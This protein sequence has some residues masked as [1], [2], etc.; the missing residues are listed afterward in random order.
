M[1][2]VLY[3]STWLLTA[4][5]CPFP[6]TFSGRVIDVML[7]ERRTHI[8][9]RTALAVMAET[10]A[11]L[12]ELDDFEAL[13]GHLKVCRWLAY[14]TVLDTG[15]RTAL[16]VVAEQELSCRSASALG[17]GHWP[18]RALLHHCVLFHLIAGR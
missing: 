5:A 8:L 4:F 15:P 18:H 14:S 16:A 2:P 7:T 17:G 3:A 10:E 1:L 6:S 9:L 11:E 13:I 12:L